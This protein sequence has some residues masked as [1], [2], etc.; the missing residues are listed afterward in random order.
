MYKSKCKQCGKIFETEIEYYSY[1]CEECKQ[2]LEAE[3]QEFEAT[4][5]ERA[6]ATLEHYRRQ[7]EEAIAS[8]NQ[9]AIDFFTRIYNA[10]KASVEETY[11]PV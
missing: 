5:K 9:S 1:V 8:G 6:L 2:K 10:Y 11:G 3:K 4:A 7:M